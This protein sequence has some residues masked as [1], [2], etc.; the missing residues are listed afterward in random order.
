MDA[1]GKHVERDVLPG[2]LRTSGYDL[3]AT[4][5]ERVHA[6]IRDSGGR[7]PGAFLPEDQ[8]GLL[9]HL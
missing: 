3:T 9:P 2:L 8:P 4:C 5:W 7:A 1:V 6:E